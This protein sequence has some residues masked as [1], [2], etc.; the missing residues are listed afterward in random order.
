MST[1]SVPMKKHRKKF[2]PT[3]QH[4]ELVLGLRAIGATHERIGEVLG[5]SH[6]TITRHFSRELEIGFDQ[7]KSQIASTLIRKAL[8]GDTACLIFLAKTRL[9]W[10]EKIQIEQQQEFRTLIIDTREA[11]DYTD[12]Q[13]VAI[14]NAR[15]R[16]KVQ[17]L[18]G[19]EE[20]TRK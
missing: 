12:E 19:K 4:R 15:E 20:E 9:G 14:I 8:D 10:S 2:V 3:D 6:D 16:G 1:V 17:A 13:L 7:I 5:V 11:D 18:P